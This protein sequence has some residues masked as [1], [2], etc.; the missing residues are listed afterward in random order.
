VIKNSFIRQHDTSD[1][2][3]ACLAS[4]IK[5]HGGKNALEH[6]RKLSGTSSQGTSLLGLKQAADEIGFVAE[7]LEAESVE[8]LRDLDEPAIL[9]IITAEGLQHYVVFYGFEKEKL[10]IGD[11]ARGVKEFTKD[12]LSAI[13]KSKTLL[14]LEPGPNFQKSIIQDRKRKQWIFSLIKEDFK[15]LIVS[16]VLGVI[17]SVFG[18]STAIF[19]QKLIDEILP[20]ED[21]EK[22]ILSLLMLTLLLLV[23]SGLAVL[24]GIFMIRQGM[25]F[26]NRLIKTFYHDLLSL[27]KSFFDTRKTG[28]LVAR[29]ND[30]RRI[31]TTLSAIFGSMTIDVLVLIVSVAF[32]FAYSP[33]IGSLMLVSL[34]IYLLILLQYN[35]PVVNFQRE[36]MSTYAAAESNF[37]DTMQG[38]TDIK[39]A[40]KRVFFEKLNSKV[41]GVFQQKVADLGKLQIRFGL[42]CEIVGVFLIIII[43][44]I[45]S[46][47]VIS[48][49]LLVGEMVALLGMASAVAPCTIRLIVSNLQIQEALIA[50]DRMYE[51]V[52]LEKEFSVDDGQHKRLELKAL[53][54][55]HLSFRFPGRKQVLRNITMQVRQ[56]EMVAVMGESGQGKSTLLQLL[57]KFYSPESGNILVDE[58]DLAAIPIQQWRRDVAYVPQEPKIFNG[59]LIYNIVLSDQLEDVKE[60]ITFCEG[61]GFGKYFSELPQGYLTIVG[62][63]GANISGG[64]KQL[65]VL[66]RAL[67]RKPKLLLLDEAT[68][69]LDKKTEAFVLD[70][71]KDTCGVRITILVTH[72]FSSAQVCHKVFILEFGTITVNATPSDLMNFNNV[73]SNSV[74][75]LLSLAHK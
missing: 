25:L 32:V 21:T 44:G 26:N 73:F 63:E 38:V 37:I 3:V 45:S 56:G 72:R 9:H 67:F 5:Y 10:I 51:F 11:P 71:L 16:L 23:R 65:V 42:V 28:D 24:R 43:F 30:T 53:N 12:E 34:P 50:F 70:Q 13:W 52:S 61:S 58:I 68:S 40:N 39:S 8:N 6:L 41:Y 55:D 27:P 62:E 35:R 66:A 49:Q 14:K 69:A 64:Q 20:A 18:I 48:R 31:Q 7:G 33:L 36:V 54:I 59:S 17:I 29:M 60:A 19:S 75:D 74:N 2:G 15:L 57:L 4:I 1:C 22:L 47:L 46:W